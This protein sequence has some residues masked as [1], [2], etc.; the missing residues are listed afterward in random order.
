MRSWWQA[1]LQRVREA[2][3][4]ARAALRKSA[5]VRGWLLGARRAQI[6]LA[7]LLLVMLFL[8]PPLVNRA[9]AKLFP[10][11]TLLEQIQSPAISPR[12]RTAAAW[13]L[14]LAWVAGGA[15]V[16]LLLWLHAPEAVRR[17]GER[18]RERERD[19]DAALPSEPSRS[20]LL[21]REALLW[22]TD[23]A[24]EDAL[25]GK[26]R[27]LDQ[28]VRGALAATVSPLPGENRGH[29]PISPPIEARPPA[30]KS[31]HVPNQGDRI[32]PGGRY[33]LE[34]VLGRGAMGVVYGARD[35]VLDRRIAL[36]EL[37]AQLAADPHLVARFR[38]EAKVVARLTHPN[39]VQVYDLVEERGRLFMA[40]EYVA[41]GDLHRLLRARG[42]L[43]FAEAARLGRALAGALGHAHAQGVVHRDFKPMNV[44]LTAEGAPKV[45][46]FGIAKFAE[47]SLLTQAGS[48]LGTPLYMSPE[49]ASGK[50]ADARADVYA[51][52]VVLYEMLAGRTPFE[53]EPASV[54]AQ[55]LSQPPRPP[56]D[57]APEIPEPFDAL[58][59]AMLAKTPG[60]RPPDMAAVERALAP[61]A[62]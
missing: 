37:P 1:L 13:L 54:L 34:V 30:A 59:R 42:R 58:V 50:P 19:A 56:R 48:L 6:A 44:L 28:A 61:F 36:K 31:V 8:L 38:Q 18:A 17:A 49:Q 60:E 32:G 22:A 20:V 14:G 46:D 3:P 10:P 45:T 62:V 40:M 43:P 26:L 5:V 53:G 33:A 9:A 27:S 4:H 52:G 11:R 39:I 41:G 55:H 29:E 7:A 21:Y 16:L 51:L 25:Q 23:P 35:T 47:S 15:S 2:A 12:A 24:L 57:A